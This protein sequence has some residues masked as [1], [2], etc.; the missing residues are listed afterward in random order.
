[1]PTRPGFL[2]PNESKACDLRV[3]VTPR[4]ENPL[5][6]LID[7]AKVGPTTPREVHLLVAP[8]IAAGG[9]PGVV[10]EVLR[11]DVLV[12]VDD[13]GEPDS[14]TAA[15]G[16]GVHTHPEVGEFTLRQV[17]GGGEAGLGA[18]PK[19][20][21]GTFLEGETTLDRGSVGGDRS[22]NVDAALL[23]DRY[24]VAHVDDNINIGSCRD[25]STKCTGGEK[26]SVDE[27][28]CEHFGWWGLVM[29][30]VV[31]DEERCL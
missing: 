12:V 24:C 1:M 11:S 18:D 19:R 13:V 26:S 5:G 31:R 25:G 21:V 22:E 30:G 7:S 2:I 6:I 4:G 3:I 27:D 28:L 9:G 29:G 17:A 10:Q 15:L 8:D 16:C 14:G 23:S 20:G